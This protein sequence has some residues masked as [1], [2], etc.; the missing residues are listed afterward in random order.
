MGS[1]KIFLFN[2]SKKLE[3]VDEARGLSVLF[4]DRIRE[5][6][7]PSLPSPSSPLL[8]SPL[9]SSPSYAILSQLSSPTLPYSQGM[10]LCHAHIPLA[11]LTLNLQARL[12]WWIRV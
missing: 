5:V 3:I 7:S 1:K 12:P 11:Y 4:V 10:L 2:M 8:S 9:L 6:L